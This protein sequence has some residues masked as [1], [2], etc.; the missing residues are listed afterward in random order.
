MYTTI[1]EYQS[2]THLH[3]E[4]LP[5]LYSS[6]FKCVSA[7]FRPHTES[8]CLGPYP[9]YQNQKR[10]NKTSI[11]KLIFNIEEGFLISEGF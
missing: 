7:A 10:N 3:F 8:K 9:K 4:K 1:N 11:E 2:S 5:N 6:S